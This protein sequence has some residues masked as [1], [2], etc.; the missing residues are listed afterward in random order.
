MGIPLF[1]AMTAA[2][3]QNTVDVPSHPAWMAC[4]F[5]AYGT[6]LS[7]IPRRLPP[8]SMLMLNDR[9]PICGH[10]PELV[11]QTLCDTAQDLECD[12][13]L[14]DFQRKDCNELFKVIGTVL[15][16]ASCPVGVSTLYA[17]DFDCPVLIPPI[18]PQVFPEEALAP[19][20]GRELWLEVSSEGT[21]IAVTEEGSRYT[22][23]PHH[24]PRKT[25]HKDSELHCHYEITVKEDRV[26][27]QLGRTPEDQS[28]LLNAVKELGV[29][30]ALGLWQEMLA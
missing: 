18:P 27:F 23:L 1:L 26:L 22:P 3:L 13:I 24:F 7:N 6:G 12:S 9:T 4:H 5:S 10:D 14:L 11:A 21:E 16:R 17:V 30:H 29:T 28:T 25:A 2:E 19:W 8:G 15:A 20:K